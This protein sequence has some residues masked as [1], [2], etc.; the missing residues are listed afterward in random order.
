MDSPSRLTASLKRKQLS[1]PE[2]SEA[3]ADQENAVK[4][5]RGSTPERIPFARLPGR[6]PYWLPSPT[7][8]TASGAT[9]S[10]G[11]RSME[12]LKEEVPVDSP[13]APSDEDKPSESPRGD[14]TTEP[15]PIA[16]SDE[17][18]PS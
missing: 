9:G 2:E 14:E 18:K 1:P 7:E 13:I 17:D 15:T 6:V 4:R 8:E 3:T 5:H 11:D 12:P 16:P 10:E